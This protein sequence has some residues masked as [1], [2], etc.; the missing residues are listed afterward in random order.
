MKEKKKK[1]KK[2]GQVESLALSQ[3]FKDNYKS[4]I[5]ENMQDNESC[6]AIIILMKGT[7]RQQRIPAENHDPN[8]I[9]R[10]RSSRNQ[11]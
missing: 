1:T 6:I 3:Q 9:E 5:Q 8:I 11:S 4:E 2:G 10:D 7:E